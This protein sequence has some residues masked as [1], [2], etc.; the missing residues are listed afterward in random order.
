MCL[1]N[2]T[3]QRSSSTNNVTKKLIINI[4][5]TPNVGISLKSIFSL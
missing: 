3:P 5:Q 2:Q 4:N 1:K